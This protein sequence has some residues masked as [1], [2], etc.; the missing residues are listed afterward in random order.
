MAKGY[1]SRKRARKAYWRGVKVARTGR[2]RN[3]YLHP[4]LKDL[5]ERGKSKAPS[6][7]VPQGGA[8]IGGSLSAQPPAPSRG[9]ASQSSSSGGAAAWGSRFG[10]RPRM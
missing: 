1:P 6:R 8:R 9:G 3:P 2:G 7:G 10:D 4:I 5:F